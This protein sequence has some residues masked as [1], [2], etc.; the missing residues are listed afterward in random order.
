[1]GQI[2]CKR[3]AGLVFTDEELARLARYRGLEGECALSHHDVQDRRSNSG[4][5]NVETLTDH[6]ERVTRPTVED[7]KCN[8][9]DHTA[10]D[11]VGAAYAWCCKVMKN[12]T[13]AASA[14]SIDLVGLSY[15]IFTWDRWSQFLANSY[16][17]PTRLYDCYSTTKNTAPLTG[18]KTP[19]TREDSCVGSKAGMFKGRHFVTLQSHLEARPAVGTLVKLDV[20][21]SEWDV[22][23]ATTDDQ[24]QKIDLLDM[25]IH[26]CEML[27]G[28][29]DKELVRRAGIL[30]RLLAIFAVSAR[31]PSPW[32]LWTGTKPGFAV[33]NICTGMGGSKY[34]ATENGFPTNW[35]ASVSYVNRR[36]FA[37]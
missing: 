30:E 3:S 11:G 26:F 35:M 25:E 31:E 37:R 4:P 9:F 1:M 29:K 2:I 27:S 23:E 33:K 34:D 7:T 6:I 24:L 28:G 20:E 19:Y 32:R 18:Y 17:V 12:L 16:S 21:G 14:K 10:S 8:G 22:L 13:R 5:D 36:H 15:G